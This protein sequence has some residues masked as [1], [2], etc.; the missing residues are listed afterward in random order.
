MLKVKASI[1][2]SGKITPNI[3]ASFD[4]YVIAQGNVIGLEGNSGAGSISIATT[5][6]TGPYNYIWS[7]G[8]QASSITS[9]PQGSYTVTVADPLIPRPTELDKVILEKAC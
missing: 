7:T 8:E 5:G 9:K 6:G 1:F 2:T 4:S 3:T